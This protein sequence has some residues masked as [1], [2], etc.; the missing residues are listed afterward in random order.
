M[1]GGS[2]V[3]LGLGRL[4]PG[5]GTAGRRLVPEC[6]GD[7]KIEMQVPSGVA[8]YFSYLV[9]AEGREASGQPTL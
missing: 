8:R 7:P 4:P 3:G 2:A 5:L 6:R 1:G 9:G